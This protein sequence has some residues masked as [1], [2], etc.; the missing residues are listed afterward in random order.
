M[1]KIYFISDFHLGADVK[2]NPSKERERR[3]CR[4]LDMAKEDAAMIYLVGDVFEFWFEYKK[5]IPKGFVRLLGKLAELRDAGI[6]IEFFI[7]NH[8]MWMFRYLDDELGI[9]I[10]RQHVI[11]EHFGKRF[12]I[13][14]GDGKGPGDSKYKLLKKIFSNTIN[15]WLFR[16]LHPDIGIRL[17]NAWSNRS[18][19][20]HKEE[21]KYFLG[22]KKEWLIGYSERKLKT[23]NEQID[24]FVFGHRHL[25]IDYTLSNGTSRY[26]NLGEWLSHNSYAVFDGKE[27][28]VEFFENPEGKIANL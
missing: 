25:P 22:E 11:R 10:H 9:P 14:H 1:K 27:M 3:I 12:F 6:P 18:R 8:D 28:K 16:W 15:Q 2:E 17:A 21:E 24:F 4:W 13:H 19:K 20:N 7:G 5:V 23:L 26:I